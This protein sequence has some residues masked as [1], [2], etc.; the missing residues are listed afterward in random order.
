MPKIKKA[1]RFETKAIDAILRFLGGHERMI[2]CFL[3]SCTHHI[4]Q[5]FEY[6]S[7][8]FI[9]S[10]CFVEG[11]KAMRNSKNKLIKQEKKRKLKNNNV[12][13]K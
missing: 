7:S 4:L 9:Y 5:C 3:Y 12:I 13:W 1:A 8:Y 10:M 2:I 11:H 6:L